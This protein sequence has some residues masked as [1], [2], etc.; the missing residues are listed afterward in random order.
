MIKEKKQYHEDFKT[1]VLN[2]Y[3]IA[4]SKNAVC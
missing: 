3:K 1:E 2:D 4:I